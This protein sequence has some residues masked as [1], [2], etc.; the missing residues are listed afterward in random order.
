MPKAR[1][2]MRKKFSKERLAEIEALSEKLMTA[3][4]FD[5]V[6]RV[7][8][9]VFGKK[10]EEVFS[11][12]EAKLAATISDADLDDLMAYYELKHERARKPIMRQSWKLSRDRIEAIKRRRERPN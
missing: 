1:R 9:P 6:E 2:L 12:L 11:T 7:T 4:A 10:P 5:S 8:G 3:A